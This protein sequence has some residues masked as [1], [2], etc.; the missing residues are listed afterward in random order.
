M[1]PKEKKDVLVTGMKRG[2]KIITIS[3][4]LLLS[5]YTFYKWVNIKSYYSIK[6][7]VK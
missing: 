5:G 6:L 7:I 3:G 4:V 2:V 1:E